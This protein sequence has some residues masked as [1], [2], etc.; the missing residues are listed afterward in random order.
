MPT[1]TVWRRSHDLAGPQ[2]ASPLRPSAEFIER[3][4][5]DPIFGSP[6]F[7]YPSHLLR[8][9][10]ESGFSLRGLGLSDIGTLKTNESAA[11]PDHLYYDHNGAVHVA[12]RTKGGA[13]THNGR[14][15]VGS[16]DW[17]TRNAHP[18]SGFLQDSRRIHGKGH[19]RSGSTIDDLATAAIA[20]S[21]VLAEASTF[22]LLNGSSNT[23]TRP[24]TSYIRRYS[25]DG[26]SNG[27]PAKRI[28]SERL[29]SFEWSPRAERPKTSGGYSSKPEVDHE[30]A[31]L[32]LELKNEVNFKN[33]T[34]TPKLDTMPEHQLSTSPTSPQSPSTLRNPQ[35]SP[36][37]QLHQSM[38]SRSGEQY[39]FEG[40]SNQGDVLVADGPESIHIEAAIGEMVRDAQARGT[41]E[42]H[43]AADSL[44]PV[45]EEPLES[46]LAETEP[47]PKKHRQI[48]PEQQAE[49]CAACQRLQLDTVDDDDTSTFWI[50]CNACKRW[51]HA[52][53]A[54][55]KTKAE[56]RGV[57]KYICKDCEPIHGPTTYVRKSSR[58][59]TAIDYAG[60]NQG[61]V[62]SSAETSTHHYIQRLKEGKM[63]VLPDDFARIRPELLTMEFMESFEGFKRPF[64]VP[65]EWNPRF[66]VRPVPVER[67]SDPPAKDSTTFT[68]I[69]SA[70]GEAG[71]DTASPPEVDEEEVID[72]GQDLLDMV[73]PRELTVRKVA[74]LCGP[75]ESVPVIDVKSQETKG[76]FTLQQWADYYELEGE[77]PIR[78]VISL[79][80]SHTPLGRLIRRP[81]VVRD[82]D[83]DDHVWEADAETRIKK[84]PVSFYCLMSAADSYTDF[85]I[86]FG[87]SSVYYH[88]LRGRKTFFFIPPEDKYLKKYEEWC[89]SDSQNETWLG[90]LCGGNC[91]RVDLH[92]GDT[93]FIPAGWIHSVWTP[94]DSLVI[95]G[96]YL[97]RL[98]Y[99]M[100]CKVVNIEKVTKV[101]PKFR[102]PYFQK[103]MWYALIKYLDEDPLPEEVL[104]DFHD[105]P[106]YV[107]LRANPIWH[108]VGEFENTAEPGDPAYNSRYYPKSEVSGWP[109]LRDFLYRTARIDAG[110][111]VPDITKRQIDAVKA[112][113]PK[114]YGD[115]L[116]M[117]KNFAIWCAW[118]IGN[119]T[120]PDWVYSDFD[121][122]LEEA[123]TAK[124]PEPIRPS[125]ERS[126][127]RKAAQAQAQVQAQAKA[128]TPAKTGPRGNGLRVACEPCRK[129][130]IKCRHKSG[131]ETPR[132]TPEIRP[133]SFSSTDHHPLAGAGAFTNGTMG[134]ALSPEA[135]ISDGV[136][137]EVTQSD[138]QSSSKKSRSKACE[139]C[140][141][142]KRRC[143][144]DQYGRID[145][146]KVAEPSKPRGSANAKR[147]TQANDEVR[148][149][150]PEI[151][152]LEDLID[153]A[154]TNGDASQ[155]ANDANEEAYPTPG[156]SKNEC[157][158][159]DTK[160]EDGDVSL[161]NGVSQE[162]VPIDPALGN[163]EEE[164]TPIKIE[165]DQTAVSADSNQN[166]NV[167]TPTTIPNG[168]SVKGE[169]SGPNTWSRGSR[170]SSRQ[171]KQVERYTPEDKR[172]PSKPYPKPQRNDRRASSAASAQTVVTVIKSERSS[173]NTSS[174]THQMAG[175]IASRRSASR[176]A[177]V[178]PVSRGSTGGESDMNADERFARELQAAENGLRRRTSMRA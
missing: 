42:T 158:A 56:A 81:K 24:S 145:P 144:H 41:R 86:D 6:T 90:D 46:T 164:A 93:A 66:G 14:A 76:H 124:K 68:L 11:Q 169:F 22:S 13:G 29:P 156:P 52:E 70:G 137:T 143:V 131:G 21:P 10:P 35:R 17:A 73:I 49:V 94:E 85:H 57:D 115:P 83:L 38:K 74:E 161:T 63:N 61:V 2:G 175:M 60:L 32:L 173:S 84:K 135:R 62:K 148:Q 47:L 107:F 91:T 121:L 9:S 82:L 75:E 59:R 69:N 128:Q 140:R 150:G 98:D 133:R 153:P 130:R 129:R 170:Q 149:T 7:D 5:P 87:G 97:T 96:N 155:L 67:D 108:E 1:S 12:G 34:N 163:T 171:P 65:A 4:S 165:R 50:S 166:G 79:E 27:P 53:C 139:D 25:H 106:D 16:L 126:S 157:P 28:K 125:G 177:S 103:V 142:S 19:T 26:P 116:V 33:L 119:T 45:A 102:Y 51:F 89:N 8:P 80:V 159:D 146:A 40:L 92:E 72:C 176:E 30:D 112:S 31:L 64:V 174:T 151:D 141:K 105:D 23:A 113:I 138:P 104:N 162:S 109:A 20:T 110:L 54:G 122:D 77:K 3:L 37:T 55:F 43:A 123:E 100:Q 111:P 71:S 136:G 172:S 101:A 167:A 18:A 160:H 99:D 15:R 147:A 154:L 118:K 152:N 95:G 44:P 117:I 78:N 132:R 168:G 114:G 58:P 178:R 120:A 36:T 134:D 127:P 48:R 88:I 39:I